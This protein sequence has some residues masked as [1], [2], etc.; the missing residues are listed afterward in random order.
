MEA[1]AG[2]LWGAIF[3]AWLL[4]WYAPTIFW[5]CWG[6]PVMIFEERTGWRPKP[7]AKI[8][9]PASQAP[10]PKLASVR[11]YPFPTEYAALRVTLERLDFTD[12]QA[13]EET[14]RTVEALDARVC[15][16]LPHHALTAE[17]EKRR[18]EKRH[19]EF[20]SDQGMDDREQ[21]TRS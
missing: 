5:A 7:K 4:I 21:P 3:G 8:A 10:L 17:K 20:R 16:L 14:I 15:A 19:Y 12:I 1:Y 18:P 13:V 11:D 6:I 2:G 9:P